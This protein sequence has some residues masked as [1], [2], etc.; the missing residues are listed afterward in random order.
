MSDASS[1]CILISRLFF[2]KTHASKM[3]CI[4][5]CRSSAYNIYFFNII[6]IK[7]YFILRKV[8]YVSYCSFWYVLWTNPKQLSFLLLIIVIFIVTRL[9]GLQNYILTMPSSR[10]MKLF[11]IKISLAGIIVPNDMYDSLMPPTV[12]EVEKYIKLILSI[13]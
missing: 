3:C 2:I 8:F 4:L 11:P 13:N 6:H 10:R 7:I 1:I 12:K 9:L 5:I